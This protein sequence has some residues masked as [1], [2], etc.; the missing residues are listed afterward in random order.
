MASIVSAIQEWRRSLPSP[1]SYENLHKEAKSTEN[2]CL[3]RIDVQ[4]TN[5][6]FEGGK[7]DLAK[8]LS[9]NFQVSHS[10]TL[11]TPMSPPSYHFGAAF[12]SGKHLLHG[13]VDT[14]G[15]FQGKYHFSATPSLTAKFQTHVYP[16][17]VNR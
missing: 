8:G 5:M 16:L 9:P 10:F 14:V 15:N 6:F 11:G 17:T 4:L 3:T 12:V 2:E 13:L 1:G 7:A